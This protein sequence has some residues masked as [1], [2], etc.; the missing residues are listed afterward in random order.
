MKL[1][2]RG[3]FQM[4]AAAVAAPAVA[5]ALPAAGLPLRFVRSFDPVIGN[6]STHLLI[7]DVPELFP[8]LGWLDEPRVKIGD[9]ITVKYPARFLTEDGLQYR[10]ARSA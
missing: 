5:K 9:T 1:T 8:D 7:D 4:L 2:R 10:P 3:L 6:Y